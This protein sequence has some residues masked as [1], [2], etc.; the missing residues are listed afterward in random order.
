[1]N[2]EFLK[3]VYTATSWTFGV[4]PAVYAKML[5]FSNK[6]RATLGYAQLDQLLPGIRRRAEMCV[7]ANSINCGLDVSYD[8][9]KKIVKITTREENLRRLGKL[10]NAEVGKLAAY[11]DGS[12]YL[13]VD[14]REI[15]DFLMDFDQGKY[16]ELD[17]SL[18]P[19]PI[20]APYEQDSTDPV[21]A[22]S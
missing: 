21:A 1:M 18:S 4:E 15:L 10:H 19:P 20:V 6:I 12:I 9:Q 2:Y 16:P 3:K 14:D 13:E 11:P 5:N 7:L 17:S 22:A 8:C